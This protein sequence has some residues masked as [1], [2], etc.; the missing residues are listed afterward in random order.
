MSRLV[1]EPVDQLR[2]AA[3]AVAEGRFDVR[4]PLRRRG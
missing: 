3:Q 4:V 2:T 1:A